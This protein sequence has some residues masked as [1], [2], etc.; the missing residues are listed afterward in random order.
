MPFLEQG[1]LYSSINF[2]L[3]GTSQDG[4]TTAQAT[5]V[6]VFLCPSDSQA[7]PAGLVGT[8]YRFSEGG[9]WFYDYGQND[10][11]NDNTTMPEPNGVFFAD[12]AT[13][14]ARIT[15]GTSNTAMT[16]EKLLGDFNTT[17]ATPRRDIYVSK[18]W[19]A[20]AEAAYKSC[21]AVD[22]TSTPTSGESDSGAPWLVGDLHSEM[23]QHLSPPNAISCYM[24]PARLS[25]VSSSL[26]PGG[27]NVGMCDGSVRFFKEAIDRTVWRAIGSMNGGEV[28]SSDSYRGKSRSCPIG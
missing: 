14:L 20:T 15:D 1:P 26:H 25:M 11:G 12:R 8:N 3:P 5:V 2:S 22:L 13:N 23:Y 9:S 7:T 10:F 16:A 6:A 21:Q 17:I 28:I 18:A 24:Y 4:N 19:P 27:V